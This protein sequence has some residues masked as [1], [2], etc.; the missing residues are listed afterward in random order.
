VNIAV[1]HNLPS[2]GG[3][4]AMVDH[5]AGLAARGHEITVFCPP[6]AVE[7]F[8][9]M[10][11]HI[12]VEV[13]PLHLFTTWRDWASLPPA[14]VVHDRMRGLKRHWS[15]VASRVNA[16]G[17][18]VLFV[19]ACR[20]VR[21]PGLGAMVDVP[22]V[23]YLGEPYRWLYEA[24]P[25][26]PLVTRPFHS[27]KYLRLLVAFGWLRA[28]RAQAR[29]ESD[30]ARAYDRVL[31]NS[32][33]SRESLLRALGVEGFVCRL[34]VD[35]LRFEQTVSVA[36]RNQLV[37]VGAIVPEK[38]VLAVIAAVGELTRP[39]P[40]LVWVGNV[41]DKRYAEECRTAAAKQEVEFHIELDVSDGRLAE[42]LAQSRAMVYAPRLE[43]F[44][45]AP[46]EAAAA[47]LPVVGIAE[48]GLRETIIHEETGLLVE[49]SAE[50]A[51]AI[52]RILG[53]DIFAAS[54]GH[55][56]RKVVAQQW[57]TSDAVGRL[58]RHLVEVLEAKRATHV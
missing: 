42:V 2:G 9:R 24:L 53:D 41:A 48:G 30:A 8:P 51:K 45:Y 56:G 52:E 44:G 26:T 34:G 21:T 47:G 43:P 1:W 22:A 31:V 49:H 55:N 33:F 5:L 36:R 25:E 10:P 38:N 6:S 58:E 39:R 3:R 15:E 40:A 27:H 28:V 14:F 54:L 35:A 20:Y 57:S 4:R 13:V 11:E 17:F 29:A 18:D 12:R 19:G 50:L 46:L 23:L 16:G 37:G 7:V 32:L